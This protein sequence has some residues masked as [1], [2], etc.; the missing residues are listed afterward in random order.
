[1]HPC[2]MNR[3][4]RLVS[5]SLIALSLG[6][7]PS[8]PPV[9]DGGGGSASDAGGETGGTDT[10]SDDIASNDLSSN[11]AE[12]AG[13]N[14]ITGSLPLYHMPKNIMNAKPRN[15][16]SGVAFLPATGQLLI[17]DDGGEDST[18]DVVPFYLTTVAGLFGPAPLVMQEL[19][20]ASEL[21]GS[22]PAKHR[23]MEAAA[24]ADDFIYVMSSLPA[25][26]E[27]PDPANRSFSRFKLQEGQIVG[28]ITIDP[29]DAILVAVT[30]PT[31]DAWFGDWLARWKDQK[32]KDGGFQVEA[33]SATPQAGKLLVGLRSPHYGAEYLLPKIDDPTKKNT[34]AGAAPLVEIDVTAFDASKLDAR[35]FANVDLGGLGF[36]GMEYSATARG[37][38]INA[39]AVEAGF[40]Y[41][42]FFWNGVPGAPPVDLSEMVPA[43]K[44]LC[45]PESVTELEY[46][47]ARYLLVLSEES[48]AICEQPA[49][50]YNYLLIELNQAFQNLLGNR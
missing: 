40:D 19:P 29:R 46:A 28:A 38:F 33:L 24:F 37:Y 9:V 14:V 39:G 16:A 3:A 15:D 48:G 13:L 12:P 26:T 27:K 8:K 47:G 23:D 11:E 34:R 35:V 1:M 10:T 30:K 44:K 18:P 5:L 20:A 43:F 25:A 49:A 21:P 50:P 17:V 42:L 6:C 4:S 32:A 36:R 31:T 7:P 22:L 45:R 41:K 2:A